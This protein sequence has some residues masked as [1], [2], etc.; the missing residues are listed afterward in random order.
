MK[1][2]LLK[3]TGMSCGGCENSVKNVLSKLDTVYDLEV[4][5]NQDKVSLSY[6]ENVLEEAAIVQSIEKLGYTVN[7]DN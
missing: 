6:D 1:K 5:H 7:R 2:L 3:V 4:D